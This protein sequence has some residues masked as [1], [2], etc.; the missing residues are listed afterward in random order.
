MYQ[1]K[2][3]S[4]FLGLVG[5]IASHIR[6]YADIVE[7]LQQLRCAKKYVWTE[8]HTK[9]FAL[10]KEAVSKAPLLNFPDMNGPEII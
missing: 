6:R 10:V 5:F 2:Q 3:L 1:H 7:P 4:S 8:I 9:A